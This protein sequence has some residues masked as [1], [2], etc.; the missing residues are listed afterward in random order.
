MSV[1]PTFKGRK[2]TYLVLRAITP[3]ANHPNESSSPAPQHKTNSTENKL[4][5]QPADC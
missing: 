4:P 1:K 2:T 3:N 5:D